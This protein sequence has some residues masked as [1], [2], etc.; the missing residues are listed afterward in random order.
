MA[1]K[2]MARARDT[3]KGLRG[4]RGS[5]SSVCYRKMAST[6]IGEEELRWTCSIGHC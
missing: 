4:S 6:E 3:E 5:R 2:L 1:A